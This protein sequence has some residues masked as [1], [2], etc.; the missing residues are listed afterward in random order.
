MEGSKGDSGMMGLFCILIVAGSHESI[1]VL[2]LLEL[3]VKKIFTICKF[4]NTY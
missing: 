3:Y 1:H 2:K 4:Q